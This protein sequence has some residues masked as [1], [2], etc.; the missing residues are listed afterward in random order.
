[1]SLVARNRDRM[2]L[3]L[4]A[5]I[6]RATGRPIRR[7]TQAAS[8]LPKLPV[9]TLNATSR[10]GA[11]SASAAGDV[12]RH[13]RGDARPVD[14]VHRRQLHLLRGTRRRRTS[15]SPGPGSR[16]M[17]PPP[18]CCRCSARAPWSSAGAAPRWCGRAGAGS[19]LRPARGPAQASIAAEPVS[20]EVAPTM[21]TRASRAVSTWSNRRPSTCIA[22]SLKAS[23]GPW[24]S[25]CTN[26][27]V[28]SWISG[29]TA[30]WPNPA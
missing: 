19:P 12:V 7:A 3:R 9:G 4:D 25:S 20:P 30:G 21:V 1:M 14:R 6:S 15:P 29:T 10:S 17:C 11:P 18:R 8:T 24:N 13:L 27:P 23:V 16:R 5:T 26:R 28:S 22:M 2:S